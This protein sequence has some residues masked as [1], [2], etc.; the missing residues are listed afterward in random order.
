MTP[1]KNFSKE[2]PLDIS[3]KIVSNRARNPKNKADETE[4]KAI[5][6]F[7]NHPDKQ[8]YFKKENKSGNL[9]IS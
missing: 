5:N 7:K 6:Y 8:E 4:L 2:N 1:N 9:A 3:I